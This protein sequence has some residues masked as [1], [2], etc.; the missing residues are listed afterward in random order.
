MGIGAAVLMV[1]ASA[2][3]G[4]A[5]AAPA[6]APPPQVTTFSLDGGTST[7]TGCQGQTHTDPSAGLV[8][9]D[10]GNV[11]SGTL[12]VN[13][14]YTGTLVPGTD[15]PALPDPVVI[16]A[17]QT[18]T[19]L[20]VEATKAGTVTITI[21]PGSGYDVGSPASTTTTIT[22]NPVDAVCHAV[23]AQTI[24]VGMR[25]TFLDPTTLT[26][27]GGAI[28]DT[29]FEITGDLPTGMSYTDGLIKGTAT[30][31]GVFTFTEKWCLGAPDRCVLEVPY[32]IA[33]FSRDLTEPVVIVP[34]PPNPAAPA[35]P[36]PTDPSFT[37]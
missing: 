24:L 23:V 8:R 37:G 4:H 7:F 30:T 25:P 22:S 15:Y 13:V 1:C 16:P 26:P 33:V 29:E 3:P 28:G 2:L 35:T 5:S 36:V 6:G 11:T 32:R 27:F 10:R 14:T 34:P 21:D 17:G 12:S 19:I 18:F 20:Q 9:I 31:P